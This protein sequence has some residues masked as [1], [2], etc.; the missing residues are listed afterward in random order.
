[1]HCKCI[2][3]QGEN[4]SLTRSARYVIVALSNHEQPLIVTVNRYIIY[5]KQ[6]VEWEEA[7]PN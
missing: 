6:S 4:L 2:D 1:M 3:L 7:F 5:C